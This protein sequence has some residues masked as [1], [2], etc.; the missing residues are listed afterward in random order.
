MRQRLKGS[1]LVLVVA[2][3]LFSLGLPCWGAGKGEDALLRAMKTELSRSFEKLDTAEGPRLYY[4]GYEIYDQE[5]YGVGAMLGALLGEREERQR[6]L[7]VDVRVGDRHLDN[8]HQMKGDSG[9]YE[10]SREHRTV[11]PTDDDEAALRAKMWLR[12][13][14][15]Y[16]DAVDRYTRVKTNKAA[17]PGRAACR[18]GEAVSV[19]LNPT[20]RSGA[21]ASTAG[22]YTILRHDA[23][24]HAAFD[25]HVD[26]EAL[27]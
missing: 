10:W 8:T 17:T 25:A 4:L 22:P 24:S 14:S 11:I 27:R 19:M 7:D 12:T 1:F 26:R 20:P 16:K 2:A 3:L 23:G 5:S 18:G 21:D 13:D 15:A 9:W 6:Y